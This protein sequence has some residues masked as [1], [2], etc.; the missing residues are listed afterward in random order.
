MALPTPH[1]DKLNALLDNDKLPGDDKERIDHAIEKYHEW[2]KGMTETEG[3]QSEIIDRLVSLLSGYKKF[4]DLD[5]IFDS[6]SDFLYRQKGQLKLDNTVIEEFLPYLIT[7]SLP[8]LGE[9]M[10]VGPQSCFSAAYFTST[11]TRHENGG[12]LHIRTKDQDF[13]IAKKLFIQTSYDPSFREQV[14]ARETYLG[15][16]CAECKTNLDKTMFQEASATAHDVKT[17][18]PGAK[19]YLLCEWLD[20]TPIS[21]APTDIDE[22]L[23]LRKAKRV[24]SQVRRHYAT[25]RGRQQVREEYT[26]YLSDNPFAPDVFR[27]LVSH[28]E[29]VLNDQDPDEGNVLSGGY[30]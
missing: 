8:Q 15:Y 2:I 11:L 13:T 26:E 12:G 20:M 9:E 30:F 1:F 17:A 7:K 29:G 22:V 25:Y 4:I 28:I 18:V 24:G 6:E 27:R 23:L 21:T 3:D 14:L 19:Y 16:I 10:Y 5:T